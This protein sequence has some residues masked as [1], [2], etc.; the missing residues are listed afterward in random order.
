VSEVC[1]SNLEAARITLTALPL[2]A[3]AAPRS[4]EVVIALAEMLDGD[5]HGSELLAVISMYSAGMDALR[6]DQVRR[7]ALD[8]LAQRRASRR[9]RDAD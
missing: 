7:G 1:D 5:I 9:G 3:A 8:E 4:A 2:A 6:E